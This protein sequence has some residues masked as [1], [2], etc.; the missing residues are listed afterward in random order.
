MT[1]PLPAHADLMGDRKFI[2]LTDFGPVALAFGSPSDV[3]AELADRGG[4]LVATIVEPQ[5]RTRGGSAWDGQE[6]PFRAA[7]A[8]YAANLPRT[9]AAAPRSGAPAHLV[10]DPGRDT[11]SHQA[12]GE[13]T[14]R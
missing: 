1:L 11:Q 12:L 9:S 10:F 8:A 2:V 4:G 6:A 7:V 14:R 3:A 13:R 5:A